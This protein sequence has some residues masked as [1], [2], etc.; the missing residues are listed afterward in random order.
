MFH[1]EHAFQERCLHPDQRRSGITTCRACWLSAP[2]TSAEELASRSISRTYSSRRA[3]DQPLPDHDPNE[4]LQNLDWMPWSHISGGN[5]NYNG[6]LALGGTFHIDEGRPMPGLFVTTMKNAAEIRPQYFG[7]A[8]IAYA[9]LAEAMEQDAEFR[10][11]FFSRMRYMVYGGAT[12]SDDLYDRIQALATASTTT[13]T[14]RWT[15]WP[16]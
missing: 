9:M 2:R 1:V 5:V 4:V 12:L 13:A 3:L 11:A 10:D 16:R 15:R 8:P 6:C 14:R 7:S